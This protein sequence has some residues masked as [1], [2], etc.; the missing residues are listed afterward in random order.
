ML[1]IALCKTLSGGEHRVAG[2]DIKERSSDAAG[3][4]SF[5][6]CDITDYPKLAEAL[7]KIKPNI[8]IH[9]AAFT[10]VDGCESD[11]EKAETVNGLGTR[12]IAEAALGCG[13]GL[14]YISTDFVFDGQKKSAYKEDDAPNPINVY[15]KTKLEGEK[16]VMDIMKDKDF[17]IIRSSWIFGID[18]RNFVDIILKKAQTESR[19]KIVSDQ[20]GSPTYTADLADAIVKLLKL[21]KTRS[22]ICGI[23]HITNSDS[24][25]WYKL[26]EKALELANIYGVELVP[27]MSEELDREAQRPAMSVLDNGRYIKL[28][29]GPLRRWEK[30]LEEYIFLRKRLGG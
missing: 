24:C 5:V 19:I 13:A 29:N 8:I 7:K 25:S 3:P 23:Y 30:A 26:A 4:D 12:Y 15:G 21:Y 18:G 1:G 20:F 22:D 10:D 11:S 28:F 6:K 2:L 17:F 27:I 9:T 14:M 16:F